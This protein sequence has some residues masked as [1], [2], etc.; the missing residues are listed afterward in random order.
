MTVGTYFVHS[1]VYLSIASYEPMPNFERVSRR[2]S[3]ASMALR[4]METAS[5]FPSSHGAVGSPQMRSARPFVLMRV[6]TV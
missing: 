4:L 2:Y 5:I 6:F 1:C 3:S